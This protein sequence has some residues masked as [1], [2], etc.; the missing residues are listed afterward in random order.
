MLKTYSLSK[1][2]LDNGW[3]IH[4]LSGSLL[5]FN[6]NA[7]SNFRSNN[8][9]DN[10]SQSL[11]QCDNPYLLNPIRYDNSELT[12]DQRHLNLDTIFKRLKYISSKNFLLALLYSNIRLPQFS[13]S[14]DAMRALSLVSDAKNTE[15]CL[16]RTLTVAK[17]SESFKDK[18]VI[19]IGAQLPL[20]NMHAWIIE[21]GIQPDQEDRH[22]VNFV[23]LMA[24]AY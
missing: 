3:A 15:S 5:R 18:G 7:T 23:P 1:N 13:N 24:L 16:Q 14:I 6:Q 21:D 8:L 17:T 2:Y 22:W 10:I 20:K 19:F 11:Y 9:P 12:T 4:P